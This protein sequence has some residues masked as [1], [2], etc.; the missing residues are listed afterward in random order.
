M[1]KK[2]WID[3][4][5]TGLD[6]RKNGIISIAAVAWINGELMWVFEETMNPI[7]R[8]IEPQALSVNGFTV[9]QIEAFQHWWIVK[10]AFSR[11]LRDENQRLGDD[12]PFTLCGYG[13]NFDAMFLK[14]WFGSAG[15]G[16]L[17]SLVNLDRN[18]FVDVLAMAKTSLAPE[19]V[20]LPN[21]K[22][23]TVCAALGVKLENAHT[24]MG[25]I[26]ATIEVYKKLC[27]F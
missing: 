14:E 27:P 11:A 17:S 5:T 13:I 4:E 19:L 1:D 22:L 15:D 21:R 18:S 24:A 20:G 8:V 23:T 26:F 7:G 2:L 12:S 9:E 16:S 6:P 25:D 10:D 3:L